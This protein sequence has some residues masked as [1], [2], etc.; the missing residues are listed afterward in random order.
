MERQSDRMGAGGPRGRTPSF[1]QAT[2]ILLGLILL[3]W[4]VGGDYKA[5]WEIMRHH[6]LTVASLI[7][8]GLYVLGL[9]YGKPS[10]RI[11]FDVSHFLLLALLIPLFDSARLRQQALWAFSS[12]TILLLVLSYLAWL[13]LLPQI[14]NLYIKV[15]NNVVIQDRITYGL[16]LSVAAYYWAVE[17]VY[18][19]SSRKRM[20]LLGLSALAV[21]N[22]LGIV[23]SMTGYVILTTLVCYFLIGQWR[24]KGAITF[25]SVIILLAAI[26]YSLPT[27]PLHQRVAEGVKE[28]RQWKPDEA[29]RTNQ[30]ARLEFYYNGLRVIGDHPFFGVGVGGFKEAYVKKIK[31]PD[32]LR[33][34][35]PHNEYLLVAT[36]LG[37]IGLAAL[38]YLFYTQWRLAPRL[39]TPRDT[40]LARGVVL[41]FVVGCLF[42]SFLTDYHEGIFFIWISALLFSG[43]KPLRKNE[44]IAQ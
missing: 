37:L 44:F 20:I 17:A 25:F 32:M 12:A 43:L 11:V 23:N 28:F 42:N 16:F 14:A 34:D 10:T 33:S 15:G 6:P 8:F 22:L 38:I 21:F 7:L 18:S 26:A 2:S 24:W 29:Q 30:G 31:D 5:K 19:E 27:S 3:L 39:P 9:F 35:N 36:Q 4:I 40:L 41:A 13:N 1:H